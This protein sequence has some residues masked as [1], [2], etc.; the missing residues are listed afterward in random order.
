[1]SSNENYDINDMIKVETLDGQVIYLPENTQKTL[2]ANKS[3]DILVIHHNRAMTVEYHLLERKYA[4]DP[5]AYHI[6]GDPDVDDYKI[7]V[8]PSDV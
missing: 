7:P 2:I 1:M 8:I 4:D 6:Y 3:F 5:V